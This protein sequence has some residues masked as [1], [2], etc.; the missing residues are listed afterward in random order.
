M[1]FF[2]KKEKKEII[3]SLCGEFPRMQIC[4]AELV[5][6][7]NYKYCVKNPKTG[8]IDVVSKDK[9]SKDLNI[10][11]IML[12]LSIEEYIEKQLKRLDERIDELDPNILKSSNSITIGTPVYYSNSIEDT[13]DK[14]I[15]EKLEE[16]KKKVKKHK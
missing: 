16:I 13:V 6:E 11:L 9:A 1:W 10:T 3:Y 12:N 2:N 7:D 4:Q 14:R 8:N 15:D 5:S